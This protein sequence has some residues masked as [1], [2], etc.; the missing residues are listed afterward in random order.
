MYRPNLFLFCLAVIFVFSLLMGGTTGKIAGRVTNQETGEPLPGANVMIAATS[1]GAA[2]D[3]EGYYTILNV[4]PG[5]YTVTASMIGYREVRV[6]NVQI[7]TDFTT[8]Q[9]FELKPTTLEM[10]DEVVVLGSKPDI[11]R[12]RTS[13]LSIVSADEITGLPVQEVSEIIELQAGVVNGHFRGGRHGEVAYMVDGMSVSD[14]Y[15]GEMAVEVENSAV[16]EI[17]VISGTFSAEYGQA[18]SGVVNIVTK[19]GAENFH[20]NTDFYVG[21]FLS[22]HDHIFPNIDDL[23]PTHI[24]NGEFS[25]TGPLP[26]IPS[27][28][29]FLTGRRVNSGG[30]INGIREYLPAD[31]SNMDNPNPENWYIERNGDSNYVSMNDHH[32]TS[33]QGKFSFKITPK[34]K[35]HFQGSYHTRKWQSYN[36]LFK[37]NPDGIPTQYQD[38]YQISASLT[39]SPNQK[40]F[41]TVK[42]IQ[43]DTNYKSYV[44]ADP[45]SDKYVSPQRLRRLGYGFYTGGMDMSHFYRNS[46]VNALKINLKAQPNRKHEIKA[47]MEYRNSNLWLHRFGLRLDRTTDWKPEK[48]PRESIHNNAYRHLPQEMA[49]WIEDKLELNRIILSAGLRF[50][51]FFPDGKVPRDLRDPDGS[52]QNLADPYKE[53]A[54]TMQWSPRLGISYPI[55]DQGAI[56][57]S[58]GH[59]FQIPNYEYLYHNSEF[60]VQPGGLNTIMG[61]AAFEPKKT[62][63]Y[64]LGLQQ[65]IA[66][67]L[68]MDITGYYKDMRNLVGTQIYEL[69]ILGDRYARY[70]NRDYGNVRGVAVSL[71]QKPLS[72]FTGS[73]DYTFQIAEGNASDPRAVFYD[74]Q[75]DPPR[76]PEIQVVPLDWDQRHT[77]NLT[78]SI[79]RNQWGIGLIGRYGSGLPYTPEYQ[80]QRTAFENSE[81]MPE[82]INFD[83]NAHYDIQIAECTLVLYTQVKNL[84]DRLNARDVFND[85]GSPQ[86]SLVPTYVPEQPLH[87]LE[88]YLT[89][90][91]FFA[92]PRQIILGVKARL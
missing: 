42:A 34:I 53:A 29:F 76:A 91:D 80:N 56:H 44:N 64:Q 84:F 55:T 22:S 36:H 89:R 74:R 11:Q 15:N 62:V 37:Y 16:Q 75:S 66:R 81:R 73:L 48:F 8:R 51:Y 13:T 5:S 77:L 65:M 57:I 50:D 58:Y 4:Q 68:V 19:T 21:D 72:W 14:P 25:I 31:S 61:N 88:D 26:G 59:F 87:S 45:Y 69:Y 82:T 6:E 24:N 32:K 90:P 60:E 78:F 12:D 7:R 2:A 83:L 79:A 41:Y 52:Y 40:Y 33:L 54:P 85:T 86:Y 27:G 67:G 46:R 10:K 18:M 3:S 70:E 1:Q 35:C 17:K 20:L 47:G 30:Y 43:Y 63:I 23:D 71:T 39:H 28:A 9:N 49:C 92:P 38:G